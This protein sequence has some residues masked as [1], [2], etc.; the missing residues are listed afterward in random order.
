M[1]GDFV[2]DLD[3]GRTCLD[4]ANTLSSTSG[5]HLPAYADLLAFAV[6]AEVLTREDADWLHAASEHDPSSAEGVLGRAHLLRAAIYAIFSAIAAGESAADED[7]ELLNAELAGSLRHARVVSTPNHRDY[8]WGWSN[9]RDL[10]A[11]LWGICRS[12]ADVLISDADRRRIRECSG[13]ECNWLFVDTSK[14]RSR[15]WCS[16]QSCGNRHK[17][18]RHYQKLRAQRPSA[19]DD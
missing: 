10:D 19:A 8:A 6:Q 12:A 16:M 9:G 7:L 11:P 3:G 4:F 5:D 13:D 15:Q 17:A 18:R 1:M 2:F 14:N